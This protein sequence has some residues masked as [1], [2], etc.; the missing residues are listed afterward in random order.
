VFGAVH[1]SRRRSNA[2]SDMNASSGTDEMF[3]DRRL[4]DVL[5]NLRFNFRLCEPIV[6]T[7]VF[8]P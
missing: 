4:F 7:Q 2:H 6:L 8:C 3:D 1:H 5:T